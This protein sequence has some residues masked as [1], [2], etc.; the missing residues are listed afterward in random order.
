M[1]PIWFVLIVQVACPAAQPVI[2]NASVG[3]EIEL[4]ATRRAERFVMPTDGTLESIS[5]YHGGGAGEMLLG[6][7]LGDSAPDVRVGVTPQTP[8][9]PDEGWQT[10]ALTSP[11]W[12]PGG[13]PIWLAWVFQDN[14]GVRY[15][16]AMDGW[17]DSDQEWIAGMPKEFGNGWQAHR[18]YSICAAYSG[19]VYPVINEILPRNDTQ[20]EREYL[21]QDWTKQGWVELYNPS[22]LSIPLADYHLASS[23]APGRGWTFPDMVLEPHK[24][25]RIWTS[26]K[27]RCVPDEELHTSFSLLDGAGL[28]LTRSTP[29]RTVDVIEAVNVPAD[30]SYGRYP[31]GAGEWY[32]YTQP[33]PG[34]GN[35]MENKKRFAIDPRH[36]SLTVGTRFQLTVTPPG[37]KVI[38][39]SDNPLVWVDP[40]G[41]LL[42]T[43]DA[44]GV[45]ARATI[46]ASSP[47]GDDVDSCEVTIVD[48]AANLSELRVVGTPSASYILGVEGEKVY[49][50]WG[51]ELYW[52]SDG[53]ET[54]Q[55]L[56]KLPE[57]MDLPK[58]L[59]TPFG[60]F[61][62][63]SETIFSSQDLV[64]WT[65]SVTM[66][67]RS[68]NHGLAYQWDPQS[69]TGY[70]YAGEYSCDHNARHVVCRG[71]FPPV[72]EPVWET[73]LDFPSINEWL[74]DSSI[75]DAARHVH[76]VV[77][78][79][80]TGHVW[81][82]TGD[83]DAHSKLLY[84]D[85]RGA[86]F[87]L[88]GMG[89]QVYRTL[90]IWF[91]A[92]YVYW[93][94]DAYSEQ[95][96]WR[97]PRSRFD[98]AGVWPC[99]TPELTEGMT[100]AGM[101]YYVTA[102]ETD[103]RFPVSVGQ[104]Y[105]ESE[106][107]TVDMKNR[108]RVLDDSAYDYKERV[109]ELRNGTLWYHAWVQD[110]QGD[111]ILILGQSAEGAYR[112][113]RG[114]LFGMKE[115]PDG[116]VDVQELLSFNSTQPD[117]YDSHTMFVQLEPKGQDA[118]GYIYF[119]GRQT[120]HRAYKTRLMWVDNSLPR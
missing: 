15:Q 29:E 36:V 100:K 103:G 47:D 79:P 38:W 53:F 9:N 39:S 94:M 40:T 106:P 14:P 13:A 73:I 16:S 6:V 114:R 37:Q 102:K 49:Y 72:G 28:L 55:F 32:F 3:S 96:C 30:Y 27:D 105:Q 58:M 41:G 60:Y 66:N 78:D 68:L 86:S 34:T 74:N 10:A 93:S 109:V 119:I 19:D 65:P 59:V 90:S 75:L 107:R 91:T 101:C 12:V 85:D 118:L 17:I 20:S 120:N 117:I 70:V 98:Q 63:C 25:L 92:R 2:G 69:Q 56:S 4:H 50:A 52:T 95:A 113:Y 97:I 31:D 80:Y 5:I 42:A 7:Y 43:Q 21:D 22:N 61:L 88:V 35:T 112:D 110:D 8:V 51:H 104:I 46:T 76:T 1:K 71:T 83:T 45:D 116:H 89:S 57:E 115:W 64:E 48:W 18:R 108:V 111:S 99:M 33:T 54:S 67:T 24:F 44:R 11:L 62:Q 81:V 84:S 26:G 87:R 82:G 77:V 23:Q